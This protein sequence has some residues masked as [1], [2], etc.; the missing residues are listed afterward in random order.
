MFTTQYCQLDCGI[1]TLVIKS[2]Q[3]FEP[4]I[5]IDQLFIFDRLLVEAVQD[6]A[7]SS[8]CYDLEQV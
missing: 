6:I 3:Y 7:L 1:S 5:D 2:E 4:N 8:S